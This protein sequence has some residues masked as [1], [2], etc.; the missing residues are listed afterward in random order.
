MHELVPR[1][2]YARPVL[3]AVQPGASPPAVIEL[4]DTISAAIVGVDSHGRVL[5]WNRSAE[6]LF[7]WARHEVVGRLPP[8]IPAQLQQEWRLQ[9]RQVIDR[10]RSTSAAETQRLDRE[11]KLIPV[12]RSSAPLMG[13]D[14]EVIGILDTLTDITAHKQL[15]EESRALAQVRE[16]EL[17]AMDLH[18]GVIQSLYALS[19]GLAAE[20][21]SPDLDVDAARSALQRSRE[22]IERL[23]EEMRSYLLDLR[24]REFA[25]RELASGLRLLLDALRLNAGIEPRLDLDPAV[26]ELLTPEVRGHLLYVAREAISNVLRHADATDVSIGVTCVDEQ[27]ILRVRDNG[28]GF[29]AAAQAR[30]AGRDQR[31]VRNMSSRARLVGGRLDVESSAQGGTEIRLSIPLPAARS[32]ED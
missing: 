28:R 16:R 7:G 24:V 25:P 18:D 4:L 19:L 27:V 17:I 2:A 6:A 12:L 26:D 29:D 8:I 5:V 32:E 10:G 31:G 22:G 11:G 14:G 9:M 13:A 21:R 20:E 30:A 15:G 1:R 23:I 3:S